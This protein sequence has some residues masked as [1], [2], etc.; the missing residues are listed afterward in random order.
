[1]EEKSFDLSQEILITKD[2]YQRALYTLDWMIKQAFDDLSLSRKLVRRVYAEN[3]KWI[4]KEDLKSRECQVAYIV[5]K[6]SHN[7]IIFE[8]LEENQEK[9]NRLLRIREEV[10]RLMSFSQSEMKL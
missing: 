8:T 4:I 9:Y 10:L 7:E 3:I 5:Y 1:M 2:D 6:H